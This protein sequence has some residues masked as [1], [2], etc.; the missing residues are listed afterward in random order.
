M[1]AEIISL[2][3][4]RIER[5][6]RK[7]ISVFEKPGYRLMPVP[8]GS[9]AWVPVSELTAAE[10]EAIEFFKNECGLL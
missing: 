6:A 10:L 7:Q 8:G 5:F 2:D 3:A 1:S 9:F 4:Y